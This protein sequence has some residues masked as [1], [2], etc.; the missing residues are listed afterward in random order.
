MRKL[1]I[2]ILTTLTV[3]GCIDPDPLHVSLFIRDKDY[4]EL[5]QYSEW[6]YNTFGA[7]LNKDA[8]VSYGSYCSVSMSDTS[9]VLYFNGQKRTER[10]DTTE[11]AMNIS[12]PFTAPDQVNILKVLNDTIFEMENTGTVITIQDY[13]DVAEKPLSITGGYLHFIR[14]QRLV[15]DNQPTEAIF[16]GVFEFTGEL[17]GSSISFTHGRFDIGT[18]NFHK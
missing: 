17:N 3:C 18:Q 14:V 12:I 8:F 1:I 13:P 7:Y 9:L 15:V 10:H 16:S 5:P 2:L 6:G 4:P 11:M